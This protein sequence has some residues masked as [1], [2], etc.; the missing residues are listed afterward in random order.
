ME[1][2]VIISD[3]LYLFWIQQVRALNQES[4]LHWNKT[5]KNIWTFRNKRCF[6]SPS[7]NT[8]IGDVVTFLKIKE[9]CRACCVF[10]WT[11]DFHNLYSK[12][13]FLTSIFSDHFA[14]EYLT[15]I[16]LCQIRG[17]NLSESQNFVSCGKLSC[18]NLCGCIH[19]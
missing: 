17:N 12:N 9:Y 5:R 8:V 10:N 2:G 13:L 7:G 14:S 15:E 19:I 6:S 16:T 1:N 18:R 3:A 4:R 11:L